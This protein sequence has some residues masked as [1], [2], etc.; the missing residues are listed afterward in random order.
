VTRHGPEWPQS[1][2][3]QRLKGS[4]QWPNWSCVNCHKKYP[5]DTKVTRCNAAQGDGTLCG[6]YLQRWR[7]YERT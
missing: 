3:Q 5:P 6:G 2:R 7:D 1:D 4:S